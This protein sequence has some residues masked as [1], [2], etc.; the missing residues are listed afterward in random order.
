MARETKAFMPDP[1][2]TASTADAPS[3]QPFVLLTLAII[4]G[5]GAADLYYSQPLLGV[6]RGIFGPLAPTFV[7]TATLLGYGLGILLLVPL[8]DTWPRRT[9]IVTQQLALAAALGV[10]AIAPNLIDA[11][12]RCCRHIRYHGPA[13]DLPRARGAGSALGDADTRLQLRR[14]QCFLGY[15]CLTSRWCALSSWACDCGALRSRGCSGRHRCSVVWTA[16]GSPWAARS[17]DLRHCDCARVLRPVWN[18]RPDLTDRHYRRRAH[19]RHRSELG[20]DCEPKSRLRIEAG[21]S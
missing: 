1:R 16:C 6:L 17:G 10:V 7:A 8:G 15:P 13:G 21:G 3:V 18:V 2:T 4:A 19:P 14:L 9:L 11:G 5:S 20:D 12:K